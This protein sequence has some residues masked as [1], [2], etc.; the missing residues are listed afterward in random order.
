MWMKFDVEM[1]A[2]IFTS[3]SGLVLYSFR[4]AWTGLASEIA[5]QWSKRS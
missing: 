4:D 3:H 1:E 2:S 5:A